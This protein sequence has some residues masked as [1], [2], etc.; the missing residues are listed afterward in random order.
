[1]WSAPGERRAGWRW[2]SSIECLVEGG[3]VHAGL[4]EEAERAAVGVLVDQRLHAREGEVADRGDAARLDLRVGLGDVRVDA[5]AGRLDRVGRDLRRGQAR[6][7]RTV[8][9]QVRL[10]LVAVEELGARL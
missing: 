10:H 6:V 4:A 7:V 2:R 5:R 1:M 8:E 3:G 9:L